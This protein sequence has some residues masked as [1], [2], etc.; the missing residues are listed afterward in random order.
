MSAKLRKS[1]LF[2]FFF[3]LRPVLFRIHCKI[4]TAFCDEH[5][6][7]KITLDVWHV[8]V[9][10]CAGNEELNDGEE[11][12]ATQYVHRSVADGFDEL[13]ERKR[14]KLHLFY[15]IA[16][17]GR[18]FFVSSVLHDARPTM[19]NNCSNEFRDLYFFAEMMCD[20]IRVAGIVQCGCGSI[21]IRAIHAV[22]GRQPAFCRWLFQFGDCGMQ[23]MVCA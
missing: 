10:V 23:W 20:G 17:A 5:K 2:C 8:C 6:K 19:N 9:W 3:L 21:F 12:R 4:S 18:F 16:F 13:F 11:S 7:E 1:H 22:D 14:K 15:V